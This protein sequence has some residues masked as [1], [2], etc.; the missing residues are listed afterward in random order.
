M[1]LSGFYNENKKFLDDFIKIDTID[2]ILS[3]NELAEKVLTT[4]TE[5]TIFRNEYRSEF[6][7]ILVCYALEQN[8]QISVSF[9]DSNNREKYYIDKKL[10]DFPRELQMFSPFIFL[11]F[12]NNSEKLNINQM[13]NINHPYI[14]WYIKAFDLLVNEYFYYS[15]QLIFI[16][17]NKEFNDKVEKIKQILN[18][19]EAVLPHDLKPSK[20]INITKQDF[21]AIR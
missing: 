3:I 12:D 10:Q 11:N 13:L 8:F 16:A 15:Q 7:N 1:H 6:Y 5:F 4:K 14:K 18:R 21:G 2:G 20:N 19:L 17:I 9:E